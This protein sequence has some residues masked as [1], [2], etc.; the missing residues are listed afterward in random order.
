MMK[1]TSYDVAVIGG[2]PGGYAAALYCARSGFSVIVLEQ[3]SPGGQ[4]ATTG[5]VDN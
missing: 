2:G 1:Q 4:M 3:L 5:Q